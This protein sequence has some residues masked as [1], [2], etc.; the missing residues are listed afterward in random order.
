[1]K[2]SNAEFTGNLRELATRVERLEAALKNIEEGNTV[3]K[4]QYFSIDQAASYLEISRSTMYRLLR[5][6]EIPYINVGRYRRVLVS[7]L[8]KYLKLQHPVG[9]KSIPIR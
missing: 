7:D 1:M 6:R 9:Y 4:D 2:F 8:E 5:N 3:T